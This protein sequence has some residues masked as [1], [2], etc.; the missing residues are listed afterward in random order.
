MGRE[1]KGRR[2][3]ERK[4]LGKIEK[5]ISKAESNLINTGVTEK[6]ED[7]RSGAHS[8]QGKAHSGSREATVHCFS[9]YINSWSWVE[10]S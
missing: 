9:V 2:G 4:A 7:E 5:H 1:W 3:Q 8:G 10:V 6:V